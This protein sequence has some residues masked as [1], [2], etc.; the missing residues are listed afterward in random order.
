MDATTDR[1]PH[2]SPSQLGTIANC[3]IQW[4]LRHNQGK[5]VA[6]R[7]A[8][9]RGSSAHVGFQA[10]LQAKID[11]GALLPDDEVVQI[12][13]DAFERKWSSSEVALSPEEKTIGL[14]SVKGSTLDD[15]V[16]LAGLYNRTVAPGIDPKHVEREL[17]L[18]VEGFPFDLL[19]YADVQER[20]N[21][22]RD[23]K[24]STKPPGKD[25]INAVDSIQR[26]VYPA[27]IEAIDGV[28][29]ERFILDYT[30]VQKTQAQYVKLDAP[31]TTDN[32]LLFRRMEAAAKVIESG[33]FQPANPDWWGCSEKWCGY[34]FDC[35]FGARHRSVHV[36]VETTKEKR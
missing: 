11:T 24:T 33:A 27:A 8:M 7:A 23:S 10:T 31:T 16:A 25:G 13:A 14:S 28:R 6:P 9:L 1:K 36:K 12:A 15:V 29:P 17:P 20:N 32:S 4:D 34:W 18:E 21:N 19:G 30:V 5:K 2:L 35:E 26:L 22:V 3:G